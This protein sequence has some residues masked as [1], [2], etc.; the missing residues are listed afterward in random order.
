MTTA[1][2]IREFVTKHP[3]YKQDSVVS[4]DINY[5]LIK[6]CAGITYGEIDCPELLMSHKT[7]TK[8]RERDIYTQG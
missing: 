5:D 8:V 2:W 1:H 3:T 4:E 7:R 6:T